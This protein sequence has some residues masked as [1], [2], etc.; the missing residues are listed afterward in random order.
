MSLLS[1][2][3][4]VFAGHGIRGVLYRTYAVIVDRWFDFRYGVETCRQVRLASLHIDSDNIDHGHRYEAARVV[5]VRRTLRQI[6]P[7]LPPN[8]RLVDLGSGK[9]RILM[10]AAEC[11][12]AGATGVEFAA[13][14]CDIGRQNLE[15]FRGRTE[16]ITDLK[17]VHGDVVQYEIEP[18]DMLFTL[19]NPFDDLVTSQVA[20]RIVE[21]L[22]RHPRRVIVCL[23][24]T[25]TVELIERI[26]SFRRIEESNHLGYRVTLLSNE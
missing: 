14:L 17:I 15:R 25:D 21:S 13:E 22:A 20:S 19:F 24:N 7:L 23:Y 12:Y 10:I 16:C 5:E 26:T 4:R 11:G 3:K 1:R 2:V 9:G 6:Q 8:A 18:R